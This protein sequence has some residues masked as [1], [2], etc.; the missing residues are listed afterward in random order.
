MSEKIKVGISRCLLGEK[1]RYDGQHKLDPYLKDVL[2][3]FVDWVPVCPEFECGLPVPR[4]A[5]R[6]VGDIPSPRLLTI[7]TGI[8]HTEKMLKWASIKIKELEKEELC[9]FVFK[10]KSPS[11][12][13]KNV[14]VYSSRNGTYPEKKGIGIFAAE[15]MKSFPLLPVEEDGRLNDPSVRENFIGKIFIYGRWENLMKNNPSISGLISFHA[16]HKLII[17]AHS[18]KHLTELGR[19]LGNHKKADKDIFDSYLQILME[20][21]RFKA[22]TKKNVNVLQHAAGYF[23]KKLPGDEKK[24]LQ[25]LIMK[26]YNGFIPLS[27]PLTLL[28]HYI[29]KYSNAYLSEQYYFNPFPEELGLRNYL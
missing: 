21:L 22:N 23:K 8:D 1:V 7:K 28:K 6:L 15:L 24:E 27:V 17:M 19:M 2:G 3:K 25:D 10:S 4:E 26:Y 18:R 14:K 12:G 5:M 20:A 16:R 11:S 9:G 13:M 29:K